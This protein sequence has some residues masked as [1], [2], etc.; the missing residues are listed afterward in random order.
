MELALFFSTILMEQ[1]KSLMNIVLPQLPQNEAIVGDML[2]RPSHNNL[3]NLEFM[4]TFTLR[5]SRLNN[6]V[7]MFNKELG[8]WVKPRSNTW[9]SRLLV[10]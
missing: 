7:S 5:S 3:P 9:F 10:E 8:F 1:H 4:T 2:V 6:L